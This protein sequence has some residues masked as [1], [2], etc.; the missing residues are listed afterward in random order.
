M[1]KVTDTSLQLIQ[2]WPGI[3]KCALKSFHYSTTTFSVQWCAA[4]TDSSVGAVCVLSLLKSFFI[5]NVVT[6]T[7]I[8]KTT[9]VPPPW[10]PVSLATA[11]VT[12]MMSWPGFNRAMSHVICYT[13]PFEGSR[14]WLR[15]RSDLGQDT[16]T[17]IAPDGC[18][19]SVWMIYDRESAAQRCTVC[20]WMCWWMA[21]TV[22]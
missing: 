15:G 20:M 16:A 17:P 10:L 11:L 7:M 19:G 8:N 13:S 22:Q 3:H 1:F 2:C 5:A 6:V 12:D 21:K 9:L 14:L 18:A 4:S